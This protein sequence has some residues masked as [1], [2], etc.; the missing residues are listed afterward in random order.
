[1]INADNSGS[2]LSSS[3]R[4]NLIR[5]KKYRSK[6]EKVTFIQRDLSNTAIEKN[7][8]NMSQNDMGTVELTEL[9]Q[10]IFHAGLLN[11]SQTQNDSTNYS[12]N[13]TN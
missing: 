7:A 11:K 4:V 1:M 13:L 12:I 2:K 8:Q 5:A 6:G 10:Q 9:T 3:S